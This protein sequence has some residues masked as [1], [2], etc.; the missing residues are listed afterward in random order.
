MK[1]RNLE[2]NTADQCDLKKKE[3]CRVGSVD[4]EP[5]KLML[6]TNLLN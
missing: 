5:V 6:V 1:L 2:K 4:N 3:T